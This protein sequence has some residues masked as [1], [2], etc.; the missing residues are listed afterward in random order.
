MGAIYWKEMADHF[1][2]RRFIIVLG[3]VLFSVLWGLFVIL[4][5]LDGGA[6]AADEFLFLNAF[7]RGSG[8]LPPLLFFIG[9]FGPIIGITLG[10]DAVNSERTQG[11]LSR[12]L[13]Q[14]I[15]RDQVFNGKFLAALTT[16]SLVVAG[17]VLGVVGL[18]MF[19]LG[20]P[21]AGQE[22]VRLLGFT[23]ITIAYLGVWLA[24]AMM[25][26]VFMRNVVASAL[27][28]I[29]IWL[30]TGFIIV[31]ASSAVA[32]VIVPE[33]ETAEEALRHFR[34]DTWIRRLSPGELFQEATSILLDPIE[35][36]TLTP[37]AMA[38]I[39][40]G[41]RLLVT[42]VAASQSLLLVWPHI[43]ALVGMLGSLVGVSYWKFMREEVRS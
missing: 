7:L 40:G 19:I 14:P 21:P 11:T 4:R 33:I 20:I 12:L 1:S 9:F 38:S 36:R 3:L 8:L 23:A 27:V 43:V 16:L 29:G 39:Q 22:I 5:E 42:P 31:I 32:D 41:E 18:E 13:A 37:L 26:S 6:R 24:L 17:M 25:A 28:A 2:R 35:G 15:Y 30:L 10:F 34:V